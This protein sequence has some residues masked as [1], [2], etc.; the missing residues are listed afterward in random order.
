MTLRYLHFIQRVSSVAVRFRE[1]SSAPI[2]M[3]K[4]VINPSLVSLP[5]RPISS[6]QNPGLPK[7]LSQRGSEPQHD[8]FKYLGIGLG[9]CASILTNCL[10]PQSEYDDTKVEATLNILRQNVPLQM[11]INALNTLLEY[12]P[13]LGQIRN[14]LAQGNVSRTVEL[15]NRVEKT[16]QLALAEGVFRECILYQ[17][18]PGQPA[19]VIEHYYQFLTR[20][21]L[22][23]KI[24]QVFTNYGLFLVGLKRFEEALQ[25]YVQGI[26]LLEEQYKTLQKEGKNLVLTRNSL[27]LAYTNMAIAHMRLN[28]YVSA[29][30]AFARAREQRAYNV[31]ILAMQGDLYS[32]KNEYDKAEK[33]YHEALLLA[34]FTHDANN[35]AIAHQGLGLIFNAMGKYEEALREFNEAVTIGMN[36]ELIFFCFNNIASCYANM[37]DL[38]R[39]AEYFNKAENMT[40]IDAESKKMLASNKAL[41]VELMKVDITKGIKGK[42]EY[43]P[44]ITKGRTVFVPENPRVACYYDSLVKHKVD[45]EKHKDGLALRCCSHKSK[46][47][48]DIFMDDYW[49]KGD[50]SALL[51]QFFD[52]CGKEYDEYKAARDSSFAQNVLLDLLVET[53]ADMKTVA[54]FT[55]MKPFANRQYVDHL[56]NVESTLCLQVEAIGKL[57]VA[58]V[59]LATWQTKDFLILRCRSYMRLLFEAKIGGTAS[60]CEIHFLLEQICML[61]E[62]I[63]VVNKAEA[64]LKTK[65]P[66]FQLLAIDIAQKVKSMELKRS[67]LLSGGWTNKNWFGSI[68]SGHTI[69]VL[70]KR[71][72]SGKIYALI[73]NLGEASEHHIVESDPQLGGIIY[74]C[75]IGFESD[76]DLVV[77]IKTVLEAEH[78]PTSSVRSSDVYCRLCQKHPV[79]GWVAQNVRNC[80][81][82]NHTPVLYQT[83]T[84]TAD[85]VPV[86]IKREKLVAFQLQSD[87]PPFLVGE[88]YKTPGQ[89]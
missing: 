37:G 68:V 85:I 48:F 32:F 51:R 16:R 13:Q 4:Q 15:F 40:G 27:S 88:P 61:I 36:P 23:P 19:H 26:A 74:P 62:A 82:E 83:E 44:G 59:S 25:H 63:R 8:W 6:T 81:C 56:D 18:I 35:A 69:Y 79:G 47:S 43:A 87:L 20:I 73:N 9:I 28:D 57:K 24:G 70:F 21:E 46:L 17:E 78:I 80:V 84:S 3:S 54:T 50:M 2:V 71:D 45:V 53:F 76:K 49:L 55:R 1:L 31:F 42:F 66:N 7:Y 52:T 33:Y 14:Y 89:N 38:E 10:V 77:F 5:T 86:I 12:F 29:E 22:T 30:H 65:T 64:I 72:A 67:Y 41:L 75:R 34:R 39:A 60:T 11:K 58:P